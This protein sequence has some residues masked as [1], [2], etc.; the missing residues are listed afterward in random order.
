MSPLR[1]Y[2]TSIITL[3]T[4]FERPFQI[5]SIFLKRP[6][7]LP[8]EIRLKHSRL[9]FSVREPMDVWVIKETCVDA[10][11]LPP[12]EFQ[13]GWTVVDIGAGLG[14]FTIFAAVNCPNGRI[15]AYEPLTSSYKLLEHNLAL[16]GLTNVTAYQQATAASP[17]LM[18]AQSNQTEAVSTRFVSDKVDD[19]D[20]ETAVPTIT[21]AELLDRLPG[22]YCHL[23]KID[24]EGCEFDLL[25]NS[26]PEL[27]TRIER[28][29][30]E[31]HDG[32]G[33]ASAA[34]LAAYLRQNGFTVSQKPNPVHAYLGFIF[35]EQKAIPH[36]LN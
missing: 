33:S 24:C 4:R 31:T 29:A 35:A 2:I 28:L 6:G 15:F 32:Y 23:M 14:D 26:P 1:Y 34:H 10:D 16:N 8:A 9:R 21:L 30:I 18:A 20:Q 17:G 36:P 22:G 12:A 27:L 25:L 19:V 5:I 7:S 11:Y 3:L 13:P